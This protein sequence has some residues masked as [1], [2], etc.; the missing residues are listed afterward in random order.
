MQFFQE[1]GQIKSYLVTILV[2]NTSCS[3]RLWFVSRG[4]GTI[5]VN[6]TAATTFQRGFNIL[7]YLNYLSRMF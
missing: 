2:V 3:L 5:T 4:Q 6:C 1:L 7:N